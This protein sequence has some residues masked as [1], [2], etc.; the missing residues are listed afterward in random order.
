MSKE[1]NIEERI[2]ELKPR[3]LAEEDLFREMLIM[4]LDPEDYK[5]K[6]KLLPLESGEDDWASDPT[7]CRIPGN[8]YY[9]D[10]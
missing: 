4:G 10:D 3:D 1:K 9:H 8:Y 7:Y 2:A 5:I 6:P